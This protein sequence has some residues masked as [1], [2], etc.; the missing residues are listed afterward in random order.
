MIIRIGTGT[1]FT[2]YNQGKKRAS[3]HWSGMTLILDA[4]YGL[5]I[6]NIIESIPTKTA[7]RFD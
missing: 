2:R 6:I 4:L 1:K 3:T 7:K 5:G